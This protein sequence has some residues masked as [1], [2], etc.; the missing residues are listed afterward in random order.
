MHAKAAIERTRQSYDFFISYA[1]ADRAWAEWIAWQLEEAGYSIVIQSRHLAPGSD[2]ADWLEEA[3]K[4]ATRLIA[5]ISPEYLSSRLS[6]REWAAAFARDPLGEG[7]ALV[8][9]RVREV[10]LTGLLSQVAY[11]DLVGLDEGA[12][13]KALLDGLRQ[14]RGRPGQVSRAA[15]GQSRYPGSLSRVWNV[16]SR[17]PHFVGR[18]DILGELR[19]ALHSQGAVALLGLGGIGKTQVATEYAYRNSQDYDIVWWISAER[20]TSLEAD[21]VALASA[22]GLPQRDEPSQRSA[23]EF[24]RAWLGAHGRWLLIFDDAQDP[25]HVREYLPGSD[26]GHLI[27]TSRSSNWLPVTAPLDIPPL[28]P[29]D[30]VAFIRQRIGT[31]S[32]A[33][34]AAL[35]RELGFLPLALEMAA[36][37]IGATGQSIPDY[38]NQLR[39][40]QGNLLDLDAT[41]RGSANLASGLEVAFQDI[42]EMSTS[43]TGLLRLF[44]FLAPEDI[45]LAIVRESASRLPSLL[46]LV[47]H[48]ELAYDEAMNL[49]Q[50]RSFV[51]RTAD[52][53][54]VHRLVQKMVMKRLT[55]DERKTW[56]AA[57]VQIVEHALPPQATDL[58]SEATFVTFLPHA[59]SVATHAERLG[60]EIETCARLL[61]RVG[62][63]LVSRGDLISAQS[64]FERARDITEATLGPAHTSVATALNNLA[65]VLQDSGNRGA[66]KTHFERA[67]LITEAALGPEDLKVAVALNNLARVLQDLGDMSAARAHFERA[68]AITEASL[69]PNHPR[70]AILQS[71][72]A[73][74][75]QDMGD[76]PS[77]RTYF[78][79]ALRATEAALGTHHPVVAGLLSD[80]GLVLGQ[81]GD[82]PAAREY[83]ERALHIIESVHGRDHPAFAAALNSIGTVLRDLGELRP[84]R[85][86]SHPLAT[87]EPDRAKTEGDHE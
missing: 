55:E 12:A 23:F 76:W 58:S 27:V 62:E 77:A 69:G 48:G 17:N 53:L 6:R 26:G 9:V 85:A 67:L 29:N 2:F 41:S 14:V 20:L 65:Q 16:P 54:S 32:D 79:R 13:R 7:G 64:T 38:L 1:H 74:V 81:L 10:E 36:A 37:Y 72:L 49:L 84:A 63:Y 25:Q 78:E 8:P 11:L 61:N 57:A 83:L 47:T 42:E 59:L 50:R 33:D 87:D 40:P 19:A 43:A 15:I 22:L 35:A 44:A 34:A 71:N 75:L 31:G 28:E 68:L 66:A 45:P 51:Q 3:I 86:L 30:S 56:A 39:R 70:V 5:V 4:N 82:M 60:V 18:Q 24:V 80:L 21:V 73:R 46:P 52:G